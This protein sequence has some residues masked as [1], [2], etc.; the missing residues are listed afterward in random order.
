MSR[1][2]IGFRY[3]TRGANGRRMRRS[4]HWVGGRAADHPAIR[5]PVCSCGAAMQLYL[6]LDFDSRRLRSLQL[7]TGPLLL[8]ACVAGVEEDGR[9]F[10]DYADPTAP[11]VIARNPEPHPRGDSLE[12]VGELLHLTPV[13]RD[14]LA[15]AQCV[16]GCEPA[17]EQLDPV[18]RW[19][20]R[21][22]TTMRFLA[23]YVES[24]TDIPHNEDRTAMLGSPYSQRWYGCRA[25]RIV[26]WLG[27]EALMSFD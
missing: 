11:L 26:S 25:C 23:E 12:T 3:D 7:W 10:L 5:F 24:I 9:T 6:G 8:F 16:I 17:S 20:P 15:G 14:E 27:P 1:T 19:C 21:C 18:Q 2:P 4:P 22:R 13:A